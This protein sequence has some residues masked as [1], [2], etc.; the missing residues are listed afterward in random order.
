M[1]DINNSF[2]PMDSKASE[3]LIREMVTDDLDH[4]CELFLDV[5]SRPPW[6]EQWTMNKIRSE[7]SRMIKKKKFMGLVAQ[8]DSCIKG[9]LTGYRL[10]LLKSVF[11][12]DQLF[13]HPEYQGKS[14]GKLLLL[15]TIQQ[16][17]KIRIKHIALLTIMN[18]SAGSFY[19]KN[20][21]APWLPTVHIRGKSILYRKTGTF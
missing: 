19:F 20:G 6:N 14:V 4:Y 8:T 5:F 2:L 12:I 3:I 9:Y 15:N 17:E 7:I 1:S 16:L 18:S 10:P 13:V 11:Y 21:F